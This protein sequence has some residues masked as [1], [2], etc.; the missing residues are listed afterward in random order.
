MAGDQPLD[1]LAADERPDVLVVED[2][3]QG[4]LQVL[5]TVVV[6]VGRARIGLAALGRR[7]A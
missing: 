7:A 2:G 5:R 3:I 6:E 4:E 1:E